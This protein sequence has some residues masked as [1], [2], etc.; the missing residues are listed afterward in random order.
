MKGYRVQVQVRHDRLAGEGR[1]ERDEA[2]GGAEGRGNVGSADET[3]ATRLL[4]GRALAAGN[5]QTDT[6]ADAH[7]HAPP[8]PTP[9]TFKYASLESM[10][11][12]SQPT[13]RPASE[14]RLMEVTLVVRPCTTLTFQDFCGRP[15]NF[16]SSWPSMAL[17]PRFL[18]LPA[19]S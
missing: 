13:R 14:V 17:A 2:Q 5:T 19:T 12:Y 6:D 9:F 3:I 16:I 1:F 10:G 18:D 8:A 11:G 7:C 15:L 4:S